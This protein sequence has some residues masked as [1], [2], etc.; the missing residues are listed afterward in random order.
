MKSNF[1]QKAQLAKLINNFNTDF[2][3]KLQ[4]NSEM[5]K[6]IIDFCYEDSENAHASQQNRDLQ[7]VLKQTKT[8]AE[9]I[10]SADP[11]NEG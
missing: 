7:P 8:V 11:V 6:E 4:V 5:L 10:F 9:Q 3:A 1:P 2:N